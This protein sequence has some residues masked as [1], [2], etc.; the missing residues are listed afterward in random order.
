MGKL[1]ERLKSKTLGIE[2][3]KDDKPAPARPAPAAEVP[4]AAKPVSMPGQ[5]GAFRNEAQK[6]L[7]RIAEKDALIDELRNSSDRVQRIPLALVDDSPYQPRLEYDPEEIDSLAKTMAIATQADPIKVR[8][9]GDR[10]ELISGHRRKR[11][12]LSLGW[13]DIEAIVE[14]RDDS[15]AELEAMLLVVGNVKLSDWEYAN[16]YR[17]ALDKNFCKTQAEAASMFGTTQPQ[18]S[19]CLDMLKLP[20]PIVEMLE[21]KPSLFGYEC[22]KTIKGLVNDHPKQLDI[23]VKGVRRLSEEGA[24]QGALKGWVLQAISQKEHKAAPRNEKRTITKAGRPVFTTK[25]DPNSV[26]VNFKVKSFDHA[27]F[28]EDLHQWLTKYADAIE[29]EQKVGVGK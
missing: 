2:R 18:V 21:A 26:T 29:P 7:D 3:Q 22:G 27:K 9:V 28:E 11:A 13:E 14:I 16:M 1:Q 8:K 10:F 15:E 6:Y 4:I 17:R 25:K 23:I 19:G 12:A 20:A 24:K 5:L